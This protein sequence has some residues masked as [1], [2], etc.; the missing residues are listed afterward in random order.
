MRQVDRLNERLP[1]ALEDQVHLVEIGREEKEGGER[2]RGDRIPFG[3]RLRRVADSIKLVGDGAHLLWC[4]AELSNTTSVVGDRPERVHRQD[5]GGGH[6]HADRCNGGAEDAE[7]LKRDARKA[8]G[9]S[10]LGAE[11]VRGEDRRRNGDRSHQRGL[12]TNSGA[13]DDVRT[14]ARAA[15]LCDFTNRSIRAGRIELGDIDERHAGGEADQPSAEEPEPGVGVTGVQHHRAGECQ[16][17]CGED[18]G[19]PVAAVQDV[20]WILFIVAAHEGH[21]HDRAEQ[22]EG[23][24]HEREE[25]PRLWVRPAH[26]LRDLVGADAQDHCADVLGSSRLKEVGAAAGA[27][28]NVVTDEVGDHACVAGVILWDPLLNFSNE[29]GANVSSLGVDTTTELGEERNE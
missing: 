22:P 2:C 8:C 24:H 29:V 4:A 25:D 3:E 23:V 9:K 10:S 27:V 18:S 13:S 1:R 26:A 6:E 20:H 7:L 19:C 12:K 11:P 17:R 21:G 14:G 16:T 5:V 15:R 28:A